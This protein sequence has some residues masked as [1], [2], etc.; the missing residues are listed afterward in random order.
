[1]QTILLPSYATEECM[2]CS[3]TFFA[4]HTEVPADPRAALRVAAD[5]QSA[6]SQHDR[7]L[8]LCIFTSPVFAWV[9]F[10]MLIFP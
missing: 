2:D 10:D 9:Y 8:T 3:F 5:Q 7:L 6:D 1:M 4:L